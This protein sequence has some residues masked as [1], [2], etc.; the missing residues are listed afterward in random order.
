RRNKRHPA[1]IAALF[2]VFQLSACVGEG[3]EIRHFCKAGIG[4]YPAPMPE[5]PL[6]RI[7]QLHGGA[8]VLGPR[9]VLG[10]ASGLRGHLVLVREVAR[11]VVTI[12]TA[13]LSVR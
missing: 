12:V 2:A 13:A 11:H 6:E 10:F 9:R 4:V 8:L 1:L 3:A 5:N 7:E